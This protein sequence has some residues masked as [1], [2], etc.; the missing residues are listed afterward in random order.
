MCI[1]MYKHF[2]SYLA[3]IK[4]D[5]GLP[6][7]YI[8]IYI[9]IYIYKEKEKEK[10]KNSILWWYYKSISGQWWTSSNGK[11]KLFSIWKTV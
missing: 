7:L 11:R 10:E 5:V 2:S 3:N 8:Y 6:K 9:Y 4:R 1:S